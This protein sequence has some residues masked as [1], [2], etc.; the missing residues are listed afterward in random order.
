MIIVT[1][2]G[3]I[4]ITEGIAEDFTLSDGRTETVRVL[5]KNS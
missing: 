3:G 2:G 5:E 4:L 1:D